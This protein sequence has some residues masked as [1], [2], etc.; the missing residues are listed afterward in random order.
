[1]HQVAEL[2]GHLLVQLN[3]NAL[4]QRFRPAAA[5]ML[6][7]LEQTHYTRIDAATKKDPV[8]FLHEVLRLPRHNNR[9][10]HERLTIAY[11][12][13]ESQ[14]RIS[15]I[16]PRYDTSI[17]EFIEQLEGKKHTWY[18]TYHHYGKKKDYFLAEPTPNRYGNNQRPPQ[19]P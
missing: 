2:R 4:I 5:D 14:L 15:L 11:I 9:P 8:A 16:A 19:K 6:H 7:Q 13:F 10:E 17:S 18:E 1:M 12:H 3:V